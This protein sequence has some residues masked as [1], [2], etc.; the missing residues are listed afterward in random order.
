MEA[1]NRPNATLI[2]KEWFDA[3]RSIMSVQD[4]GIVL[5][6]ACEYVFR[7]ET[8]DIGGETQKI[9]FA[10]IKPALDSDIT[11]YRERCARNAANARSGRERVAASGSE[12]QQIQLQL[13]LQ[14]QLQL[15]LQPHLSLTRSREIE[16]G[17]KFM[18]IFGV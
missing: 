2:N 1:E 14:P 9:V 12:W 18:G 8:F 15:Q 7:S 4:L 17:S 10:M 6:R 3:A 16:K 11:K 5:V 13:Q